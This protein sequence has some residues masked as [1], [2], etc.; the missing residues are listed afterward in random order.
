MPAIY[1]EGSGAAYT[2][3]TKNGHWGRSYPNPVNNAT[4]LGWG[5]GDL[6]DLALLSNSKSNSVTMVTS[7]RLC[8]HNYMFFNIYDNHHPFEVRTNSYQDLPTEIFHITNK[9]SL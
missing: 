1:P 7:C 2:G 5:S 9:K 6:M 4:F 3:T 8:L